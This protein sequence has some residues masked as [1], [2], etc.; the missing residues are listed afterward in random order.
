MFSHH[1]APPPDAQRVRSVADLPPHR[2]PARYRIRQA[3]G[4][5]RDVL[6]NKRHRQVLDLLRRGP[7]F[8]ASPLR[9]SDAVRE[10]RTD[11]GVEIHTEM[12]RG[13][14]ASGAGDYGVYFLRCAIGAVA[15]E[16]ITP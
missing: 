15:E 8:A 6:L 7:V 2:A 1:N 13:D 12:Y 16:G 9:I 11:F 5:T 10:L 4:S 3:D 14:R